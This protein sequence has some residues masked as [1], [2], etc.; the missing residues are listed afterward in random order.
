MSQLERRVGG[1]LGA[2][3]SEAARNLLRPLLF[4]VDESHHPSGAS[5]PVAAN[6]RRKGPGRAERS[7]FREPRP[8][9]FIS[10]S[11]EDDGFARQL[12]LDLCSCNVNPWCAAV[13]LS[14]TDRFLELNKRVIGIRII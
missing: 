6:L 11:R 14:V 13:N 7:D 4:G 1:P 12:Y 3:K 9:V 8:S 2:S 5:E 10:H